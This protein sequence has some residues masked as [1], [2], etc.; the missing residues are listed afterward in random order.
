VERRVEEAGLGI[1]TQRI[2]RN[3]GGG[4]FSGASG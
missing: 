2:A 3:L 4:S 1:G